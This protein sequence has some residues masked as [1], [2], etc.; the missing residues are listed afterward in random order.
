M[1]QSENRITF[2]LNRRSL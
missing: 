2:R 1:P